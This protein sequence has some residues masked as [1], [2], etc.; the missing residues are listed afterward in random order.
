MER[1]SFGVVNSFVQAVFGIE[2]PDS[3][4]AGLTVADRAWMAYRLMTLTS[5]ILHLA[6]GMSFWKFAQS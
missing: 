1:I 2:Y 4:S 3:F 6:L 5:E